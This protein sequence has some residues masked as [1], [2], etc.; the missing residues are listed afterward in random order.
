MNTRLSTLGAPRWIWQ[1]PRPSLPAVHHHP[2]E[3]NHRH[4]D[5]ST[6]Q[7]TRKTEGG[8]YVNMQTAAQGHLLFTL[9]GRQIFSLVSGSP[10]HITQADDEPHTLLPAT[11]R[12]YTSP[13]S[14]QVTPG[15]LLSVF[16]VQGLTG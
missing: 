6:G 4:H 1:K 8:I 3:S 13:T 14:D 7:S 9:T 5:A 11:H 10:V 2:G 15:C 12:F 16:L